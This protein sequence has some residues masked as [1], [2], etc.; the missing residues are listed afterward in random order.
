[1]G[2][3]SWG[4]VG[5]LAHYVHRSSEIKC[6][7]SLSMEIWRYAVFRWNIPLCIQNVYDRIDFF[8]ALFCC[9]PVYKTTSDEDSSSLQGLA[10]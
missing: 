2:L 5:M 3:S 7:K 9:C 4:I 8:S 10:V 1:M 6:F